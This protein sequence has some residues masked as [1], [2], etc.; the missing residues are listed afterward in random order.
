M[1]AKPMASRI[2]KIPLENILVISDDVAQNP[3]RMRLRKKGSAGGQKGLNDIIE[4]MGSDAIPRLRM[5][6]GAKPHPD[7]PMADWVLSNLSKSDLEL[8]QSCFAP[9]WEGVQQ[10]LKGSFDA[11]M[12]ICNSHNPEGQA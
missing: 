6:V 7:Y 2:Y 9:A 5:G 11:A 4:C 3:G 12:Q 8:L 1:A 10:V